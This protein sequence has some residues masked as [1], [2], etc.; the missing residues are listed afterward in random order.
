MAKICKLLIVEDQRD[1]RDLLHQLFA[2]EGYRFVI[3]GDGAEMR[4]ALD[5]DPAIDAVIIDVL[6]PGDVNGLTL[7]QD[8]AARGLP[9]ILVTGDHTQL[10]RLKACGHRYLL[11]PFSLA[12]FV[13]L[14]EETLRETRAQCER[15]VE[16]ASLY[17]FTPKKRGGSARDGPGEVI[18]VE[19]P[20]G[21]ENAS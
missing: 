2:S 16:G 13:A 11:K 10:E 7:A 17:A 1:I 3:V 6:L 15:D 9:A 14:I 12:S 4:R 8:A 19:L 20:L 5:S 21:G 18:P